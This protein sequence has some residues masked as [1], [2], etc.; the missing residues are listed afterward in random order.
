MTDLIQWTTRVTGYDNTDTTFTIRKKD[1]GTAPN[2]TIEQ[3][4]HYRGSITMDKRDVE[5]LVRS[6]NAILGKNND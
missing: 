2:F 4:G 3:S 6:L 5:K 1:Q